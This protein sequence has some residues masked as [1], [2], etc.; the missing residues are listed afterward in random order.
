[1]KKPF[2]SIAIPTY[3]YNGKGVEYLE[4]NLNVLYNQ[5]FKDFE[6]IISDHSKD[7]LI[8]KWLASDS[9]CNSIK[10]L[11]ELESEYIKDYNL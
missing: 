9:N 8:E 10:E 3:G 6:V 1:M 5:N 11:C 2:F 7:N 4:N